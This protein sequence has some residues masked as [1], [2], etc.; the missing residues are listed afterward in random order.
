MLGQYR[1]TDTETAAIEAIDREMMEF[2]ASTLARK[3][4]DALERAY[5]ALFKIDRELVHFYYDRYYRLFTAS[6]Y[7]TSVEDAA[8]FGRFMEESLAYAD[9]APP[10]APELVRY[11]C[12]CYTAQFRSP[13]RATHSTPVKENCTPIL[14]EEVEI[15]S[16]RYDIPSIEDA[17]LA[18]AD[19]QGV[20]AT[21]EHC[22]AFTP[23]PK[24]L[25]LNVPSRVLLEMA[26]GRRT[27]TAIIQAAQSR[28]CATD[29]G[30]TVLATFAR[31]QDIGI[32]TMN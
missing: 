23:G 26:D 11:E 8:Q 24:L 15:A 28:F 19:A 18:G 27:I 2:F 30:D 3:R 22:I 9:G 10:W 20:D 32:V 7:Q 16:F 1:L 5:P 25:R 14:A 13:R 6:P 4:R 12:L 17:L 31:Y 21:D 29:L